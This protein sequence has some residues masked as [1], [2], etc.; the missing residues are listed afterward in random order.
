[1]SLIN[2]F[3]DVDFTLHP[4]YVAGY[5]AKARHLYG[6]ARGRFEDSFDVIPQSQWQ[7]LCEELKASKGGNSRLVTRIYNQGNEGSCVGNAGCQGLE[8]LQARAVGKRR[9][10]PISA[11]SLYKQIGSSPNSGASVE[12][13]VDRLGDTGVL[14][15]DTPENRKLFKHVMSATGFSQRW[16]DGWKETA[17]LFA[18]LEGFACRSVAEMVSALFRGMVV[19]V[20]RAGHSILYCDPVWDSQLFIDYANS[21]GQWGFA[22]GSQPYG[23]GRD[24][25]RYF[26][27]SADW[28]YAMQA[29]EPAKWDWILQA[30]A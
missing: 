6:L 21:W 7:G 1:M 26:N 25:A 5:I 11:M 2:N 10:I 22:K 16:P 9:V 12:D 14:P 8:V 28:C 24:S 17:K 27:E 23:F 15:L 4:K 3:V 29:P 19:W 20:G 18:G 13:G 30:A